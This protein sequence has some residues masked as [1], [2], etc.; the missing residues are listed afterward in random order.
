[1]LTLSYSFSLLTLKYLFLVDLL[2]TILDTSK[3][4]SGKMHLEQAEF[5]ISEIIEKS[6]DSFNILGEKK[7]LE[8]IWDP[9][10]FSILK[11][12]KVIGDKQRFKQI[13]D[14]LL[15]NAVKFT[16]QGKIVVRAWASKPKL[17]LL[18]ISSDYGC[19]IS[20]MLR[21]LSRRLLRQLRKKSNQQDALHLQKDP[22]LI[23]LTFEVDDTGIGIP[24]EK[25]ASVFEN[26]VQVKENSPEGT[27]LGLGIVQ[28]FVRSLFI[29]FIYLF[30]P[31]IDVLG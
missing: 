7:D 8:M 14:N 25:R 15:G 16:S 18:N 5:N 30:Y 13:L 27:G 4:E 20:H 31:G 24:I 3:V 6:V 22:Y 1:M 10:D 21:C 23:E 9:C 19:S 17:K 29:K 26:Y 12:V 2:N 28:S 11:L